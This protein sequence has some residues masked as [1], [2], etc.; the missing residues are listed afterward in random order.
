[1]TGEDDH[2]HSKMFNT[3]LLTIFEDDQ[4]IIFGF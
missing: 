3:N 1:M 2:G 4:V